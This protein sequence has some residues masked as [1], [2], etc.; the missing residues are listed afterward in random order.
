MFVDTD[1]CGGLDDLFSESNDG[2]A[3]FGL[4]FVFEI[5]EGTLRY[6]H[7]PRNEVLRDSWF[8][9]HEFSL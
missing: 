9:F 1:A 6:L 5:A 2:L 7:V 8:K 4:V 3:G